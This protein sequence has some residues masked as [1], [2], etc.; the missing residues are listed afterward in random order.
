M[1]GF[2]KKFTSQS[3]PGLDFY[4]FVMPTA[5]RTPP[6]HPSQREEGRGVMSLDGK[7]LKSRSCLMT[8]LLSVL[9]CSLV[10]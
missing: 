4:R 8:K 9:N 6:H 10:E 1:S 5:P 7:L 2:L 3:A